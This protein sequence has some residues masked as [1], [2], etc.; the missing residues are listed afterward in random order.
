MESIEQ[1]YDRNQ[2]QVAAVEV[3]PVTALTPQSGWAVDS[4]TGRTS[5]PDGKFFAVEFFEFRNSGQEVPGYIA[6]KVVEVGKGAVLT[7]V[8]DSASGEKEYL[9]HAKPEAGKLH[10]SATVQASESNLASGKV[11]FA[12]V[13]TDPGLR[14]DSVEIEQDLGRMKDKINRHIRA[15]LIDPQ[16]D[17]VREKITD[18]GKVDAFRWCTKAE[19]Q[20]LLCNRNCSVSPH[21]LE[22]LGSFA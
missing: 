17:L 22:W 3:R 16:R 1:W 7:V 9:L 15:V 20:Q 12:D 8:R 14:C 19:V 18:P 10:V 2:S 13:L 21:L 6:P 5:R 4:T 11:L